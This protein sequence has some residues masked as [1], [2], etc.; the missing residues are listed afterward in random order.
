MSSQPA[1]R[2]EI[3]D[4]PPR[5]RFAQGRHSRS[6]LLVVRA[7]TPLAH[8]EAVA[9]LVDIIRDIAGELA[10]HPVWQMEVID[11]AGKPVYRLK[12]TGEAVK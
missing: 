2:H 12:V 3:T 1:H 8:K 6:E 11:G 5:F 7:E 4:E 10:T 9:V